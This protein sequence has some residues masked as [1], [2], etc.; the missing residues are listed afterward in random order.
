MLQKREKDKSI[1]KLLT[2]QQT[3]LYNV[4]IV[5]K[6]EIFNA[7][8]ELLNMFSLNLNS[9][10]TMAEG[11][12]INAQQKIFFD[13]SQETINLFDKQFKKLIK[14]YFHEYVN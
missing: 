7:N 3:K 13:F 2:K 6:F 14:E 8:N 4:L 1:K 9:S 12:S 11:L 10:T 5:V